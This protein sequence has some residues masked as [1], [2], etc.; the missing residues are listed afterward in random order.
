M[1][2][3]VRQDPS[4][5]MIP[6]F[7]N[8]APKPMINVDKDI[9][10]FHLL[11]NNQHGPTAAPH[12]HPH[13]FVLLVEHLISVRVTIRLLDVR[14]M[15]KE[16][17]PISMPVIQRQIPTKVTV[18]KMVRRLYTTMHGRFIRYL[19]HFLFVCLSNGCDMCCFVSVWNIIKC[20]V[21]SKN[22]L[23]KI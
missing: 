19:Y 16:A 15:F 12:L 23:H 5:K 10:A 18:A 9:H 8:H 11:L 3:Y 13:S 6:K 4:L 17:A 14:W 22:T 20:T 2:F 1:I 21:R 7:V